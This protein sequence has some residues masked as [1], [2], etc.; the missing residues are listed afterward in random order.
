VEN[1]DR[2]LG[3]SGSVIW[4]ASTFKVVALTVSVKDRSVGP[5]EQVLNVPIACWCY[6]PSKPK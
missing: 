3:R 4:Q 1:G 6:G 2:Q 5:R